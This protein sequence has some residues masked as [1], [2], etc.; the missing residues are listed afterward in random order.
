MSLH[1]AACCV[2]ARLI[3]ISAHSRLCPLYAAVLETVSLPPEHFILLVSE[4][5]SL[6]LDS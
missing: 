6:D 3:G 1:E 5:I 2:V 4:V